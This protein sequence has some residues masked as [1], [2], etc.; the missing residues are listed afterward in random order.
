MGRKLGGLCPLLGGAGSLSNTKSPGPRPTSVQSGILM[1]P[2]DW[3]QYTC[4]ENWG[5][6]LPFLGGAGYPS[7]TKLPRARLTSVP[8]GILIHPV[9]WPK[10]AEH[11]G[12]V[13][14]AG[15]V[16]I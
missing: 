5:A 13:P 6:V 10:W 4:A 9:V 8:G 2:A 15:W 7:D 1:R 14:L 3:P 12:A 11:W 16:P